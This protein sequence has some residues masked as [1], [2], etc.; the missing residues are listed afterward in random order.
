MYFY[1]ACKADIPDAILTLGRD[2]D[3]AFDDRCAPYI[4]RTYDNM[5][6]ND[7]W[8]GDN[9]TIDVI[10]GDGEK[11]FRLYLTALWMHEAEL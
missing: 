7:Y 3:K 10:V 2:G 5:D 4:R 11:T 8:I 6:S 9:H 1:K